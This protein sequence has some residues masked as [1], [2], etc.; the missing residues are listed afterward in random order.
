M[1]RSLALLAALALTGCGGSSPPPPPPGNATVNSLDYLVQ[2]R[3]CA[4]DGVQNPLHQSDPITCRRFD[5]GHHQSTENFLLPDGSVITTWGY[6][7]FGPFS[8]P[9]DGGERL[10]FGPTTRIDSTEDGGT[11]NR[12]QFFVGA[13]CGG[14]GWVAYR[15]DVAAET[16][17][18]VARLN[19]AL[20]DPNRCSANSQAFTRYWRATV[21]YPKIGPVDSIISEHFNSGSLD[22]ASALERFFWAYGWGRL[23]WQAFR[24]EWPSFL[25][26]TW[27]DEMTRRCPDFGFNTVN[28]ARQWHLV[29]CR[30]SVLV[31]AANGS[32][33]GSDLWDPAR[34]E[35]MRVAVQ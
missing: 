35:R 27:S 20:D 30:V 17:Q 2:G 19:I 3:N 10:V 16:Q 32:L 14:T 15:S 34:G 28:A 1:I 6:Y 31:E 9:R 5:F 24:T 26:P 11:P 25:P 33:R 21:D 22:R 8:P 13:N 4:G 29:D 12:V 7:P 18:L 23:V